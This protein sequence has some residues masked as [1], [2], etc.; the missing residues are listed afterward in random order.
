MK[1]LIIF[2]LI[3]ISCNDS[4]NQKIMKEK[5]CKNESVIRYYTADSLRFWFINDK[6]KLENVKITH[7]YGN[8][9]DLLKY[10]LKEKDS[11]ISVKNPNNLK[12]QDTILIELSNKTE[13][14]LYDF[15]NEPKYGGKNFLGCYFGTYKI[16]EKEIVVDG[17]TLRVY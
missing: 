16:N 1:I 2:I 6:T 13:Y 14:R 4:K 5:E 8:K 10:T 17:S 9:K 12:S 7:L 15:K 11:E 3:L